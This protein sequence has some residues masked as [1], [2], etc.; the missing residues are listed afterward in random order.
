MCAAVSGDI[1]MFLLLNVLAP[2]A[3]AVGILLE[4]VYER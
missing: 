4:V 3:T 1:F 2:R